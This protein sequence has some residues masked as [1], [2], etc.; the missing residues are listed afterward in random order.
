MQRM[1]NFPAVT[2]MNA[3]L[4]AQFLT[5]SNLGKQEHNNTIPIAVCTALKHIISYRM[6]IVRPIRQ[7]EGHSFGDHLISESVSVTP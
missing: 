2:P 7:T 1:I 6:F 3:F 4:S 5:A